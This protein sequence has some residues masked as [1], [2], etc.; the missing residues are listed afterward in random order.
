MQSS[1]RSDYIIVGGGV[2]G[3]S[4]AYHL[5]RLGASVI[6]VERRYVGSGSS[7]R[8]AA[9]ARAHFFNREASLL[10]WE[11]LKRM[12]RLGRVLGYNTLF[13]RRGYLW[14]FYRE[15]HLEGMRSYMKTWRELGIPEGRILDVDE[16]AR[17]YPFLNLKGIVGGYLADTNGRYHHD[18]VVR[19]YWKNCIKLGVQVL[20]YVEAEKITVKSGRAVGVE[21]P[22]GLLE[23][24]KA[25]IL[26]AGPW[27]R[28][29]A[30]TAGV[31]L[32]IE[33]IRKEAMVTEPL[34]ITI[35][36]LVINTKVNAYAQQTL[37]GE[38]LL[39]SATP[40]DV[41]TWSYQHTYQFPLRAAKAMVE[42]I[43]ALAAVNW[44]RQW[45]GHYATT[46]D[47]NPVLGYVDEVEGLAVA[48]GFSGHG[49][50]LAPAV[51]EYMAL[52]LEKG[53]LHPV[54]APFSPGRFREGRLIKED[55]VIG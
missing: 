47:H 23:A 44:L 46:P 15:E 11:S 21:T 37:R 2:V 28:I 38:V 25:I 3:L 14:L 22:V 36:P 7:T 29:L 17:R 48:S 32:P 20:E 31:D 39:S 33:P 26:A 19:A 41:P 42:T 10:A 40:L 13:V 53:Y 55:L 27:T 54:M 12:Y 5:A 45:A 1:R 30:K 52:L 50:M 8:N 9:N 51:G 34:K 24:D 43:P 4:I 49:F 6:V 16:L 35:R 18:A